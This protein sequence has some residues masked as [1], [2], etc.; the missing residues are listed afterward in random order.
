MYRPEVRIIRHGLADFNWQGPDM[1]YD[2]WKEISRNYQ[3]QTEKQYKE[4][5]D[6]YD[7]QNQESNDLN[8][9]LDG[10][11]GQDYLYLQQSIIEARDRLKNLYK[12]KRLKE[13]KTPEFQSELYNVKKDIYG[14]KNA[15]ESG[16]KQL[17][18]ANEEA[19]N[20]PSV[21]KKEWQDY[22][23]KQL[24]L[25][26]DQRDKDP[27]NKL[28][29]DPLFFN[30]YDYAKTLIKGQEE[31]AA[32]YDRETKDEILHY[33]VKYRPDLGHYNEKGKFVFEPS[34]SFVKKLLSTDAR[35]RNAMIGM[36]PPK[37]AQELVG[38]G[39]DGALEEAV[40]VQAK[41]FLKAVKGFE[42]VEKLVSSKM[43]Y[44]DRPTAGDKERMREEQ[45]LQAIQDRLLKADPRTF[46]DLIGDF[47]REFDFEYDEK[48]NVKSIN[49][50]YQ[51]DH[52][53]NVGKKVRRL[54]Q[55]DVNPTD[56]GSVQIAVNRIKSFQNKE[57]KNITVKP[58]QKQPVVK[59]K[60]LLDPE[61]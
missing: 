51:E 22:I 21:K 17:L 55:V 14:K 7:I 28:R 15:I 48:G 57:K 61:D 59:S 47:W 27:L 2:G 10:T 41:E 49:A 36:L 52:P 56:I 43:K 34:E 3:E 23:L 11:S 38:T 39:N 54:E 9:V 53:F 25:P 40:V 26:P 30:S 44:H 45:D 50:T 58:L 35:F 8:K 16:N 60:A 24:Q 5:E 4:T 1:D 13:T 33:N 32:N 31:S 18:L 46:N 29:T 19:N 42:P 12:G 37:Q 6:L 20:S